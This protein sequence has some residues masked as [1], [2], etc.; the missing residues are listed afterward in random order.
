MKICLACSAGGHLIEML[1][2]MEAFD[3]HETFFLT[4]K[5]IDT[6]DLN[7]YFVMDPRRNPIR[8]LVNVLQSLYVFMKEKPK[9]VVSS[10]A[11]VAIP[12]CYIGKLLGAK[13]IFI[14]TFC[15]PIGG[16]L[17]GKLTYPISGL[18][19]VQWKSQL[20]VYNRAVYG[21]CVV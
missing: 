10:G 20:K 21:G 16:S 17:S 3:G 15:R 11:G 7:G 6:K 13:I 9:V 4:F 5:R 8:L 2:I 1:Q 18:F 14:E 12:M 19:L